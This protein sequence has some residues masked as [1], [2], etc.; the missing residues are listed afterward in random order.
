MPQKTITWQIADKFNSFFVNIGPNLAADIRDPGS[1][2]E[3][4][5]L[6]ERNPNS[7]FIA[8]V[9]EQEIIDTV[10]KCSNKKST[11]CNNI[12]MA[13][14]KSTIEFISKPLSYICNLSFQ[15]GIFPNKMKTAK[16]IPLYKTGD[17]HNFTNYRPVSLLSQFSKVLEKLFN[18]RLDKFINKYN[19][20]SDSQYGFRSNRSTSHALIET[21]E[22]ITNAID[23]KLHSVGIFIDLKKA[24][25]TIHHDILINKLER[26]GI[27]GIAKN[28]VSSYL[29]NRN[30]F[31]KLG[32]T[33]S[34]CLDIVFGVPQGSVLGPKLFILYINDMC[35]VSEKL[36]LILF[37]DDTNIFCAGNNLHELQDMVSNEMGKLKSWFDKNK[38]SLNLSKTKVML[39]SN[40]RIN[41]DFNIN[42]DGISIERVNENKFLG[43]IIDENINWKTHIKNT[44]NKLSRSI[45]IL[46]KAKH[47]LDRNSLRI[48]YC[49]LVLPYL[50]YCSEVWGN[51]YKCSLNAITI[52]QKRAIRIIN[53]A[54][55]RDH[56]NALFIKSKIIK[57]VDIV[58]YKT[59]QIMYKARNNQLPGNIQKLFFERDGRYNLR[60]EA[61][62]KTLR[63]RTTMKSFCISI[64][65]VKLWNSLDAGLQQC[66]SVNQFK[67]RY[68]EHLF[69]R[70]NTTL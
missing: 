50:N 11:D 5:C 64:R 25:D 21:V 67:K 52:L 55:F 63:A 37:A 20:L 41:I 45:S 4:G 19:L 35:N 70:Y 31:V 33:V 15:T 57:F 51:T 17:K 60:G 2:D 54:G 18:S 44:L 3:D 40:S 38:L 26:Y 62:L 23:Q 10:N 1:I 14:V 16:V 65:G 39:F 66:F 24:F 58:E 59:A 30:Q 53:N 49:S 7:M 28:W 36:K 61:N 8:A 34:S 6:I 43:V 13:L 69:K 9:D 29:S 47:V 48:L 32:E 22:D 12:D 42:I 68:K 27:R 56:T 46:S